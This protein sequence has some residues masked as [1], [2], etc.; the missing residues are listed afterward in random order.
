MVMFFATGQ[1]CEINCS[2]DYT[3]VCGSNG[4]TYANQ[5]IMKVE[6]CLQKKTITVIKQGKCLEGIMCIDNLCTVAL[7]VNSWSQGRRAVNY[8]YGICLLAN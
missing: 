5:C 2:A 3:P 7:A 6:A 8:L 1:D 4:K